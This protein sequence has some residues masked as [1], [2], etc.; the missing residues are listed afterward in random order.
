MDVLDL[1]ED[2][3]VV[4]LGADLI[5]DQADQILLDQVDQIFFL[6]AFAQIPILDPADLDSDFLVNFHLIPTKKLLI[7]L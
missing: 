7:V 6:E 1:V 5:S 2:L 3:V 4:D